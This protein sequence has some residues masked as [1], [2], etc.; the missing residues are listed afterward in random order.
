MM[1]QSSYYE[2]EK[3]GQTSGY[4]SRMGGNQ[5]EMGGN[6]CDHEASVDLS[7]YIDTG[8]ELLSDLFPLKQERLKGTYSYMPPEGMLPAALYGYPPMAQDRRLG[9]YE[10]GGVIVKEETRGPHRN[11]CNT[12]QYQASQC[13]QTSVHLPPSMEGIHPALRVLK[14][15]M[16]GMLPNSPMKDPANKGK[17]CLSKDSMEY[18]LRRERNNIAVRKSR[19]KAKRRNMET[20]QRALEFMTENEKLRI[21]IQQ[22]T[23]ELDALKGV[24]RQIPE[25]ATLSKGPG[26]CS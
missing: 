4:P 18:R 16:S 17:K 5:S 14:G 24:F 11:V 21:R 1:S 15:S 9:C 19:D 7:T 13:G 23:Q 25:A 3:R 26:G 10:S 2:C 20:H 12:L 8:E 22:L 6:L